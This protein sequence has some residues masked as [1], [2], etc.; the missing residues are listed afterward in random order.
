MNNYTVRTNRKPGRTLLIHL[1][2]GISIFLLGVAITMLL[3][4][5]GKRWTG[6]LRP[7]FMDLCKPVYNCTSELLTAFKPIYSGD[8][9]CTGDAKHVKEARFSV[10][11]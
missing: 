10:K 3:T 9:F 11:L 1:F 8:D 5:V 2:H 4:E 6:R 7:H